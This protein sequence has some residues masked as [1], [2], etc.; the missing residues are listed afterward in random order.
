M[1]ETI[2]VPVDGSDRAKHAAKFGRELAQCYDARIEVLHVF[3]EG[4]RRDET[5]ERDPKERGRE[6]LDEIAELASGVGVV[7]DTHLAEGQ[8]HKSI[9]DHVDKNDVDLVVMGRRVRS[10]LGERLIGTSTDRVLRRTSTPVLTVP[11]GNGQHPT[12][13]NY[14]NILITTD[15]SENAERAAPYGVSIARHVAGSLHLLN[16]VDVQAEA[17]AF[18]AGGVTDEF[19]EQLESDGRKATEKLARQIDNADITVQSSVV[20]GTLHEAIGEYVAENGID[21]VVIASENKSKLISQSLR[22]IT[23]RVL[24]TVNVP[25]LVVVS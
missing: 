19:I 23:D 16:V 5:G 21:L 12:D 11:G 15:G 18:N 22:S 9:P 2:L 4:R 7:V 10:G 24:R 20:R 6:I 1:F 14:E 3:K 8:P 17:G 25:V 13:I